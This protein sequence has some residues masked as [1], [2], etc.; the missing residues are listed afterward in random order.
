MAPPR[1]KRG[2][3]SMGKLFIPETIALNANCILNGNVGVTRFGTIE[4]KRKAEAIGK[5][6]KTIHKKIIIKMPTL[7]TLSPL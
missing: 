4:D 5:D 3:A 6:A 2:I 1:I 7:I